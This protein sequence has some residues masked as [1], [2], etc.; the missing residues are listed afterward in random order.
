MPNI[1]RVYGKGP[2]GPR[3]LPGASGGNVFTHEQA[4]PDD[5]WDI[6][7]PLL[8]TFLNVTT[9]DTAGTVIHGGVAYDPDDPEHVVITF[10]GNP[11]AGY[12]YFS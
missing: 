6:H 5:V 2:R 11:I 10:G 7:L 8:N 12:A 3:G 1:V 4:I 9:T